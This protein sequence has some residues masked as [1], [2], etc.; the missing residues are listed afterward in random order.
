MRAADSSFGLS[1]STTKPERPCSTISGM[2]PTL[3]ATTGTPAA[4]ASAIA[5]GAFS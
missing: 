5:S 4:I 2:P 1:G 3:E